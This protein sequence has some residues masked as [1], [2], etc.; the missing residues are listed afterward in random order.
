MSCFHPVY[1][2]QYVSSSRD[3]KPFEFTSEPCHE[4]G[5]IFSHRDG[6]LVKYICLPCD[7]CIGC[8]LEYSKQWAN[9][10]VC[11]SLNYD[12]DTNF[13]LTL[14]YDD[15][16]IH[17]SEK[18]HL[19][20][21][22]SDCT[23]FF[24]DFRD[25]M[26]YHYGIQGIR[27]FLAGEYGDTTFRPHYHA[28]LFNCP[29]SGLEYKY[30]NNR[31]DHFFTCPDIESVWPYGYH[32]VSQFNWLTAAYTARYILKKQKGDNAELY[33]EAGIEP[34]FTRMSRM[35]GIGSDYFREHFVDIY[36][37]DSIVLPPKEGKSNVVK[38]PKY[39]DNM[40]KGHDYELYEQVKAKR[41]NMAAVARRVR[42]EELT[43]PE[44]EF[45]R[46]SEIILENDLKKLPRYLDKS[47]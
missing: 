42:K 16:H 29:L 36:D 2:L 43:I 19:T 33:E 37:T 9:R 35:P 15:E 12:P 14:T 47:F 11:E 13:F 10:M 26:S 18:G 28:C 7:Q 39:F 38:P 8:R 21:F 40:L 17:T 3:R 44:E 46:N 24:K 34:P 41:E 27:F 25:R 45:F 6:H 20:L 30:S 1:A 32:L 23:K 4:V 22:P 31:G 5:E